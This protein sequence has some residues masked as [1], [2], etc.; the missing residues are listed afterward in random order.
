MSENADNIVSNSQKPQSMSVGD[1]S[2]SQV[3]VAGK[4]AADRYAKANGETAKKAGKGFVACVIKP[5]GTV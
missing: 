2:G 5:S 3:P 1:T 4:I